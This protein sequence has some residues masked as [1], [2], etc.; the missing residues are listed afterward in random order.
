MQTGRGVAKIGILRGMTEIQ[1]GYV[2]LVKRTDRQVRKAQR[3]RRQEDTQD[4]K[5][6][7]M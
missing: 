7:N 2:R 6:D 1:K 5:A 4:I 3:R